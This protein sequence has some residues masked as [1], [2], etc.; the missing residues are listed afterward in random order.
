M[1][2]ELERGVL[3]ATALLDFGAGLG[4]VLGQE[5][6]DKGQ[7]RRMA[8]TVVADALVFH[9][10]L[11]EARLQLPAEGRAVK[12]PED[13]R[14]QGKPSNRQR[15]RDEWAA[16]LDRQLLA[17]LPHG[18]PRP[19][20]LYRPTVAVGGSEPCYGTPPKR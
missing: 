11:A 6:D 13:L 17:H 7:T 2:D 16:I 8:M 1:A 14:F 3:E 10:A 15:V 4:E 5:D 9:S 20:A 12:S 19:Q 18:P